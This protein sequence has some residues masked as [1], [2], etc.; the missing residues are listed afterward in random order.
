MNFPALMLAERAM[1]TGGS[2]PAVFNAANE[3]AVSS[4]VK[5]EIGFTDIPKC[6]EKAMD[7]HKVI[8]NPDLNGVLDCGREVTEYLQSVYGRRL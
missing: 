3:F 6:I 2:M 7:S 5:G 1:R 8:E 4:F